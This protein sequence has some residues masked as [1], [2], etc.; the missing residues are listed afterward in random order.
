MSVSATCLESV[1]TCFH[2]I[3]FFLQTFEVLNVT[4]LKCSAPGNGDWPEFLYQGNFRYCR[5]ALSY[6][7]CKRY[8]KQ[9]QRLKM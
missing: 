5:L 4:T 1:V 6:K 9:D 8:C 2:Y 3:F 7:T